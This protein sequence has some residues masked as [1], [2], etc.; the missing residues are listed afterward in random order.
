MA[1]S[2]HIVDGTCVE[3]IACQRETAANTSGHR[4]VTRRKNGTWRA[5]MDFQG[6]RYDLGTYR[7]FDEAVAARLEGEKMYQKFLEDY[8]T[9]LGSQS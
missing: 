9:S 7:S 8:Y 5:C 2:I 6:K 4:G 1:A 3:R